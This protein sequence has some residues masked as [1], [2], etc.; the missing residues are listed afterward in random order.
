MTSSSNF[1]Q[2]PVDPPSQRNARAT[3]PFR[4]GGAGKTGPVRGHGCMRRARRQIV[5]RALGVAFSP[6]AR[7]P[8]EP[9]SALLESSRRRAAFTV[10]S[11]GAASYAS[12][13]AIG[14]PRG[15]ASTSCSPRTSTT[16]SSPTATSS[17]ATRK[18]P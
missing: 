16:S 2:L 7:A 13:T 11:A 17:R 6:H 10:A 12:S 15:A 8:C 9:S 18:P 5:R 14:R 4:P 3:G 1:L